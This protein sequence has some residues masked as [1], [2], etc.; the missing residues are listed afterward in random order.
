MN[1]KYLELAKKKAQQSTCRYLVSAIGFN[2][3]GDLLGIT[4][5]SRRIDKEG[6]S[7][8]AEIAMLK[9]F[10]KKVRTIV[11]CR[12]NKT[13][14]LLPIKPCNT[15]QKRLDSYNINVKTII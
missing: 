1:T 2:S 15:C 8:H 6:Y 5:N 12:V 13:G 4:C 9:R 7:I 11:I 3:K 10:G 14:K